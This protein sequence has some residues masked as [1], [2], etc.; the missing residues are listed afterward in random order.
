V[1]ETMHACLEVLVPINAAKD[2]RFTAAVILISAA[3][4]LFSVV[5]YAS[6]HLS[7]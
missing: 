3:G 1:N 5:L 6:K 4:L 2:L 7:S